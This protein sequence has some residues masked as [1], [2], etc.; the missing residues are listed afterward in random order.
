MKKTIVVGAVAYDAKVV[1][2]WE[3]IRAYFQDAGVPL[4]FVLFSNYEAQVEAL[5]SRFIDVAWNTN[6]A[7]VKT[8]RRLN[9]QS[10]VLAMR[11]TDLEFTSKIVVREESG[12]TALSHI[13]GK[14]MALGSRDSAQAAIV[15][16]YCLRQE[17]L[18]P[19]TDYEAVR[20]NSD[21]GKHGD[22]GR[23]ENEVMTALLDGAVDA[24][25]VSETTWLQH[26]TAGNAT[27]LKAVYTS[28]PYS[29]CNFTALPDID[30][31]LAAD[32]VKTLLLMDY[33]NPSHRPILEMEGL[34]R[35]VEGE[36]SGYKMIF[37]AVEA[38]GYLKEET[39]LS[40]AGRS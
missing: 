7:F 10:K 2:I 29:H 38:T 19:G 4:D 20:F 1:P 17:G 35:W 18:I 32:F 12:I 25:A 11:D 13:K 31:P 5:F 8:D 24:G 36:R 15:P 14:R 40:V 30:G 39:V 3:G 34:K 16:E 6:L 33:N 22:T 27:G 28:K 21:V 37:E 9:G 26:A 23:S